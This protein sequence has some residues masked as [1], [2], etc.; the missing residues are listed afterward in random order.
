M[1]LIA[2]LGVMLEHKDFDK[3]S[4]SD[5]CRE[6]R[7]SR[8]TFYGHCSDTSELLIIAVRV[9]LDELSDLI[10]RIGAADIEKP[11][12]AGRVEDLIKNEIL[13]PF[14]YC[15]EDNSQLFLSCFRTTAGQKAMFNAVNNVFFMPLVKKNNLV[16]DKEIRYVSAFFITGLLAII[17]EWISGGCKTEKSEICG[18]IRRC[19][20]K[21]H[22][23]AAPEAV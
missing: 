13:I 2:A 6:A 10:K 15:I 3:I 19:L 23:D 7:V 8:T 22:G 16:N 12:S 4:I 9:K 5:I 17:Y 11:L 1:K 20:G 21:N 14:L 18:L